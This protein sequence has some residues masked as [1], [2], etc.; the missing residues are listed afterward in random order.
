M[1]IIGAT[2]IKTGCS[3]GSGYDK[4]YVKT[5]DGRVKLLEVEITSDND[6]CIGVQ[7]ILDGLQRKIMRYQNGISDIEK[8]IKYLEMLLSS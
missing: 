6:R 5:I 7:D 1:S 8:Q 3:R 2:V 4:I